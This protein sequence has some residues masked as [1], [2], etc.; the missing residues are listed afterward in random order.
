[1]LKA[2]SRWMIGILIF[3]LFFM[4]GADCN[5]S[6]KKTA[7]EEMKTL[8]RS[9][10][11]LSKQVPV[12]EVKNSLV[13]KACAR[14]ISELDKTD[15]ISYV[16]LLSDTG[17][18]I[19]YFPVHGVIVGLNTYMTAMEQVIEV[20]RKEGG[21]P[22]RVVLE[23][24]DSDGTYGKNPEGVFFWTTDGARIEWNG[25]F[26]WTSQPLKITQPPELIQM[27]SDSSKIEKP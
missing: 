10:A 4:L 2:G 9:Q 12:P 6:D 21:Y 19:A 15:T 18:V 8:E 3:S 20:G 26:L 14:R 13:R 25:K 22:D 17:K 16:Y 5:S 23:A 1:M 7:L 24:P 11:I 27:I